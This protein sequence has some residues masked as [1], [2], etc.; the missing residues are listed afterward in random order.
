ML[1]AFLFAKVLTKIMFAFA[2]A[3]IAS[4]LLS[5]LFFPCQ[6]ESAMKSELCASAEAACGLQEQLQQLEQQLE[7]A[8]AG[9]KAAEAQLTEVRTRL[10]EVQQAGAQEAGE[11]QQLLT[12][13]QEQLAAAGDSAAQLA[14]AQQGVRA[15]EAAV[16]ELRAALAAADSAACAAAAASG[17]SLA[18]AAAAAGQAAEDRQQ[19]EQQVAGLSQDLADKQEHCQAL[20]QV[21]LYLACDVLLF[22]VF[23]LRINVSVEAS[24]AFPAGDVSDREKMLHRIKN[25]CVYPKELF[26]TLLDIA[27]FHQLAAVEK[28]AYSDDYKDNEV[29]AGKKTLPNQ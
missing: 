11:L 4:P 23:L 21:C 19:L 1:E 9:G 2:A 13:A 14:E 20:Q 28:L 6:S 18:A 8:Q 25:L 16:A 22:F 3:R 17:D 7:Q 10:A 15:G 24:S 12:A 26:K 29:V 5:Y 27:D